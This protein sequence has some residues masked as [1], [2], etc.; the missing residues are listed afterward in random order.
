M[1]IISS[2]VYSVFLIFSL[3][4]CNDN[5]KNPPKISADDQILKDA[6]ENKTSNLQ[7]HGIGSVAKEL[8]DDTSGSRHQRF[9]LTLASGQTLLISHNIDISTKIDTLSVN[10]L[11]E[12]YGEYVW[13]TK[14]GLVHWT[15]HD[16][17]HKHEDGW[18]K[19]N[20]IMYD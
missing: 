15:H 14:G 16:P 11:V 10:D 8:A 12:F 9:I 20:G 4:A 13:N 5:I 17:D 2:L 19:Y 7:V 3:T 18:L 1:K 6:Y